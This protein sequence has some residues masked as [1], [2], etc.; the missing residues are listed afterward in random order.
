M[1]KAYESRDADR[2]IPLLRSLQR[3]LRERADS[4][5]SLEHR[6]RRARRDGDTDQRTLIEAELAN[7]RLETRNVERELARLG[8][9]LD[10]QHPGRILIPGR[11]GEMT[12]GFT[13]SYGEARVR[14]QHAESVS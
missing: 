10:E 7:H 9:A 4:M 6:L 11:S 13:W 12:D 3:E 2:L 5:R 14:A 8:C 1:K